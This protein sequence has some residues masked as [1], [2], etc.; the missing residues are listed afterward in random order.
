MIIS[1]LHQLRSIKEYP[2]I[3]APLFFDF[4]FL[5][6]S[7]HLC[8]VSLCDRSRIHQAYV[9]SEYVASCR[10]HAEIDSSYPFDNE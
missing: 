6:Q 4:C 5:V 8:S 7:V 1:L 9:A 10:I 2:A 3:A